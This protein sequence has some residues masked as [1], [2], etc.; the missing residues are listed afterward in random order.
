MKSCLQFHKSELWI[1]SLAIQ[2][3]FQRECLIPIGTLVF[4]F[5]S[6]MKT[7]KN[8]QKYSLSQHSAIYRIDLNSEMC[9]NVRHIS[10]PIIQINEARKAHSFSRCSHEDFVFLASDIVSEFMFVR[11]KTVTIN[12]SVSAMLISCALLFMLSHTFRN[13]EEH[14][15]AALVFP[16]RKFNTVSDSL[17]SYNFLSYNIQIFIDISCTYHWCACIWNSSSD[18]HFAP[19]FWKHIRTDCE[20]K[21]E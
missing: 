8:T 15:C 4:E 14:F 18:M 2:S 17:F 12:G 20:V 13:L 6:S 5:F 1:A 11:A 16:V 7:S 9:K 3:A 21:H 10:I 19:L